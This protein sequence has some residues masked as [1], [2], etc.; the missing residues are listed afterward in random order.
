MENQKNI[1]KNEIINLIKKDELPVIIFGAGIAGKVLYCFCKEKGI[2][3]VLFCDNSAAKAHSYIYNKEIILPS[4]LRERYKDAIILISAADINDVVEQLNVLGYRRWYAAG[5]FLKAYDITLSGVDEPIEFAEYAVSTCILCHDNY[6]N[7]EKLF[8]RSV[9]IIITERCSLRCQDCS[10]LMQYFTEPKDSSIDIL[11][12]SIDILCNVVDEVNECRVIGG[13]PFM[14]KQWYLIVKR[15]IDEPKVRKIMIYTNG[16]I[17]PDLNHVKFLHDSKVIVFITNYGV[18][19]RKIDDFVELLNSNSI[20]YYVR[21]AAGWTSCSSIA[22]H[23]RSLKMQH[24]IFQD[25]CAK[26]LATLSDGK[27]FRCPFAANAARLKAVPD[28]INDYIDIFNEPMDDLNI[29]K[30]KNKIRKYFLNKEAFS[31]CNYCSGRSLSA[32]EIPAAIQTKT[33]LE[34]KKYDNVNESN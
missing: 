18:L 20:V 5:E 31:T 28:F 1:I 12:D 33:P 13:E 4:E 10:N 25:C 19:S 30:T 7:P 21:D 14:N 3:V 11:M 26:H 15:L 22:K 16:T 27:L 2:E 17:V 24:G 32:P 6:L 9:D 23:N 34:Y 8:L 29:T